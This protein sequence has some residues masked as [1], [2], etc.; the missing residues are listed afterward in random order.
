MKN[1]TIPDYLKLSVMLA[2][3]TRRVNMKLEI[4]KYIH[5]KNIVIEIIF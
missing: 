4:T 5:M 3:K 2:R 1:I